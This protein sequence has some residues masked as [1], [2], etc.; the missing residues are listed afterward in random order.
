[1]TLAMRIN[2]SQTRMIRTLLQARFGADVRIWLFGSRIRDDARG[3]DFDLYVEC[4]HS[5]SPLACARTQHALEE[6]LDADVD[7]LVRAR[8]EDPLPIHRIAKLSG[9]TL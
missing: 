1:M 6:A 5:P 9:K 4:E 2:E 3:G 8:D 7:L